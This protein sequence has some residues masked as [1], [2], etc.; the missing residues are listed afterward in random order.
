MSKIATKTEVRLS[1][2]NLIEPRQRDDE[3][4]DELVY[5]TAVLIPKSDKA[6][7]TAIKAAVKEA[8]DE[9]VAKKWG[10]KTPSNLKNPIRDGDTDRPD[11]EVYKNH[12]FVNAKGPKGGKEKPILLDSKGNETNDPGVIYSGVNGRVALQFYAFDVNGNRGVACGIS[13]FY[14][15][16]KGEPLGNT[17]TAASA[18]D[19]FG[20]ATPASDAKKDFDSEKVADESADDDVW[21]S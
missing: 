5:S 19:E 8:L 1:Y 7:M 14:S 11:D 4:P 3:H 10:G 15:S 6:T 21:G 20:I 9:G 16:E 18:R 2:T 13:S 12:F 17:V